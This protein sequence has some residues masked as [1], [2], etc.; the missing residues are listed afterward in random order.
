MEKKTHQKVNEKYSGTPI[1]LKEHYSK[2]KLTTIPEM[3]LDESGL[4]HGGFIFSLAD[5]SAMLAI[6]HPNVVLGGANCRFLVPVKEGDELVAEAMLSNVDGKKL[7]VDVNIK[8]ADEVI[9]IGEFYCFAPEKH[10]LE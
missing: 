5:Y 10:V 2:V 4:I 7:V 9:F 6:N 1:E 3:I 8:R